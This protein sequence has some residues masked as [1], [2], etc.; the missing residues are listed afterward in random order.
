MFVRIAIAMH[1]LAFLL[2][3]L[4]SRYEIKN[5][6]RFLRLQKQ[7]SWTTYFSIVRQLD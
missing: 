4:L 3:L 7:S 1:Y 5:L 2:T 6:A